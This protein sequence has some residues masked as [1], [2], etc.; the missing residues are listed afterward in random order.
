MSLSGGKSKTKQSSTQNQT[1]TTALTDWS[2]DQW[3]SQV[4]GIMGATNAF[5]SRPYQTYDRPMVAG[6]SDT[7]RQARDMI[8]A[9]SGADSMLGDAAAAARAGGSMT[10]TPESVSS[11]NVDGPAAVDYRTFDPSRVEARMN[12]YESQVVDAAGAYYD[13][14]LGK[15]MSENQAR[16]TQSGAFGG[17]RHGIADAE[18]QRTSN[19]DRSQMMADLRYRGWNDAVA[20]DERESGN[21]YNAGVRNSDVAYGARRDNAVR[22]DDTS[23]FN[24]SRNDAA[25]QFNSNQRLQEASILGSLAGQQ[26]AQWAQQAQML[27]QFG[28]TEREIEQARL[29][30]D[31]AEFDRAAADELQRFM[32]DLQVRQSILGSTPLMTTNTGSGSS[33]GTGSTSGFKFGMNFSPQQGTG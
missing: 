10:W 4:D 8:T 33:T 23:R 32:L 5:T 13:E 28:A 12:P 6:L 24:A 18:L 27:S 7:Q 31:R 22:A 30:A 15:R 3:Q 11:T 26:N 14:Q 1:S 16:A 25:S 19:M 9:G 21:L 20:G 2:R 17:S 29:L